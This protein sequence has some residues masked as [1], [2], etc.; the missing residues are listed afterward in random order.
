VLQEFDLDFSLVKSKKY[1]VF[2]E[3][4]LEFPIENEEGEVV[5]SFPDENIFLIS[6][7]DPWY[8]DILIYLH[9]LKF[10]LHYS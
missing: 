1:L 6:L 5:N 9:T 4:M 7:S 2:T 8:K 10:P 3:L